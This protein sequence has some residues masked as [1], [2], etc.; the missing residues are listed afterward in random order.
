MDNSPIHCVGVV[1]FKGD[2]VLMIKR[3]TPPRQGEWSIPGGRINKGESQENAALRELYEE[4]AVAAIL[5]PKIAMIPAHF[6]GKN[7]MLHDF[8]A[9]WQTGEPNAG[10][11]AADCAFIHIN[12]IPKM[13]LWDKT[14][15]L[16]L[17]AY[18]R[19]KD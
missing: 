3:G 16:I 6:E 5:G 8:I 11:D 17:N 13:K 15:E 18:E 4:T 7:Y 1:C 10:D 2:Y 12:D 9:H 14:C 19:K